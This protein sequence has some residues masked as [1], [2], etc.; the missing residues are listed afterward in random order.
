VSWPGWENFDPTAHERAVRR[1]GNETP[2]P[3]KY[4]AKAV[5]VDGMRFDSKR[6]ARRWH[7]LQL[8]LRTGQIRSLERQVR[9]ELHAAGGAKVGCYIA[10]FRYFDVERGAVV[11]E[12]AKGFKTELYLW[13]R[14]HVAAEHGIDIQEV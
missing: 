3:H 11:V 14:R 1:Q 8:R 5:V 7:E 13:K 10:D 6:E 12:D 4:H 9:I 2:R